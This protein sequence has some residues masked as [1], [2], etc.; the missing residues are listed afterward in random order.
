MDHIV[1]DGRSLT[2]DRVES[3]ALGAG[4]VE[5]AEEARSRIAAARAVVDGI[6]DSGQ[7]VAFLSFEAGCTE[8]FDIG[9]LSGVRWPSV[10]GFQNETID[11][12]LIAPPGAWVPGAELP[13]ADPSH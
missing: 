12:I 1:I 9:V 4:R 2:L 8:I 13:V 11:G 6:L 10:I 5:L 3:V 7:V